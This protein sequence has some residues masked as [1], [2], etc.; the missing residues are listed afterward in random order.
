VRQYPDHGQLPHDQPANE[1]FVKKLIRKNEI[2][3]LSNFKHSSWDRH[4]KSPPQNLA[5]FAYRMLD[6]APLAISY[7]FDHHE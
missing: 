5:Q 6:I 3:P 2:T 4:Q 7:S 1:R